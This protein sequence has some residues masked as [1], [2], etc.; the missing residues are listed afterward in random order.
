M[1]VDFA[2]EAERREGLS[3]QEA[4]HK[5]CLLRFR[6]IMPRIEAEGTSLTGFDK[7]MFGHARGKRRF[8]DA[9]NACPD[10]R[11]HPGPA[12]GAASHEGYLAEIGH[13]I[14]FGAF[15]SQALDLRLEIGHH[16]HES[17]ATDKVVFCSM[18]KDTT[19]IYFR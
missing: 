17:L 5:A 3:P 13:H 7:R 4:I 11:K 14:R 10:A 2:L 8:V 12:A 19:I 9:E 1:M 18:H 15:H 6:P 16:V